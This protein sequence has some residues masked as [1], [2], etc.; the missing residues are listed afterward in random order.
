MMRSKD[1]I[2]GSVVAVGVLLTLLF[3]ELC[4][5]SDNSSQTTASVDNQTD[6]AAREKKRRLKAKQNAERMICEVCLCDVTSA[7]SAIDGG[8]TS[9]ELCTNRGDGGITPSIGLVLE[10]V[11]LCRGKDV[12]VHVLVRPR[13]GGFVY[14]A[15]M[16]CWNCIFIH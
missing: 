2:I 6:D 15:G 7:T 8:A 16:S 9:I 10:V 12:E 14:S 11:N 3:F 4:Y 1:L 13:P 5:D